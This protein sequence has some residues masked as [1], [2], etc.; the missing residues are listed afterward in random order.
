MV[1]KPL[2]RRR[3]ARLSPFFENREPTWKRMDEN[4]IQMAPSVGFFPQAD[5]IHAFKRQAD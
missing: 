5:L 1:A 2:L 4:G 3:A